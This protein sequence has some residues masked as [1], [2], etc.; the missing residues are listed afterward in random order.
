MHPS[1]NPQKPSAESALASLEQHVDALATLCEDLLEAN[2]LLVQ[3]CDQL[4]QQQ[5]ELRRKNRQARAD[6]ERIL[7]QLRPYAEIP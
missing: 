6:V 5:L 3:N 7:T 2:R 4:E 1:V